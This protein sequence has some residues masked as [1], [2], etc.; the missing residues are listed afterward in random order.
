MNLLNILLENDIAWCEFMGYFNPYEDPF[1]YRLT[2]NIPIFDRPAYEKYPKY[3]FVYDK[4]FVAKSQ[5]LLSGKLDQL[6]PSNANNLEFPIFIKPRWGHK[7]STSKN[8]IKINN[9]D[10]LE[11]YDGYK[12]MMWSKYINA[13]EGNYQVQ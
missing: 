9:K 13:K 3:N 1:E 12:N 4:L 8:C 6:F 7:T 11:E 10:E 2:D 5:G